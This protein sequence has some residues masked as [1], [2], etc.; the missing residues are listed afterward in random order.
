MQDMYPMAH[1][2]CSI[3]V[4]IIKFCLKAMS[5][6]TPKTEAVL[7]TLLLIE[8]VARKDSITLCMTQ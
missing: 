2:T 5:H 4:M 6:K 3:A 1:G 7:L 8:H